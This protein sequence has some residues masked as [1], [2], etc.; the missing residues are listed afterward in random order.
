VPHNIFVGRVAEGYDAG[1]EDM[2]DP[3]VLEPAVDF[4]EDAARGGSA[5]EFAIGTGR[6]ALPLSRRGV[7]VHG[8]DI[9]ADMLAQ[10]RAKP[11]AAAI[12]VT[13]G[14]FATTK[15]EGDF[16]LVYLVYNTISNLTT[17]DEQVACF[18]NAAAH[19]SEGGRFV[20]ELG[21]PNLRRF[22]PGAVA[23]PFEVSDTHLGF[24]ELDTATQLGVSR[25]YFVTGDHVAR[26]DTPFRYTWPAELDLMARI[27]GLRLR[28]RWGDWDRTPFTSES[29]KHISVWE[30]AGGAAR[31]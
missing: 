17:Q 28:E 14:D 6:V 11:G 9:S 22:P 30:R 20:I 27:A 25:H 1:S 16:E 23:V 19:L 3:V 26:F 31:S 21:Q 18:C 5:L 15:V 7:A 13:I 4:L 12:Q 24:D 29:V 10:L 2:Y 8:I